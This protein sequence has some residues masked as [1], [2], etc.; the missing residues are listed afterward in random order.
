MTNCE[1]EANWPI[2]FDGQHFLDGL[3]GY[4][5]MVMFRCSRFA[6]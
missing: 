4:K 6:R 2:E 5:E 3:P 1:L